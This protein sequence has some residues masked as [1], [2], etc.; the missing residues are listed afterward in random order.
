MEATDGTEQSAPPSETEDASEVATDDEKK[1]AG[2]FS[3][4]RLAALNPF[5]GRE[6]PSADAVDESAAEVDDS[7]ALERQEAEKET[8]GL[9][10]VSRLT[11]LNPFGGRKMSASDGQE[12][13]EDSSAATEDADSGGDSKGLFDV[14]R[15]AALNPFGGSEAPSAETGGESVAGTDDSPT[16]VEDDQAKKESGGMFSVS[17]L[18]ALNPFAG[19]GEDTPTTGEDDQDGA[20]S[21]ADASQ[22]SDADVPPKKSGGGMFSVSRLTALNPFSKT[23]APPKDE[24]EIDGASTPSKSEGGDEDVAPPSRD[25]NDTA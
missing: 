15:L 20:P 22:A 25:K 23:D 24:S 17:R 12:E 1:A 3:V 11:A 19:G 14:S 7:S 6:T 21:E 2:M 4:A 13:P 16:P 9:F 10:D 5:G 18:A 8:G